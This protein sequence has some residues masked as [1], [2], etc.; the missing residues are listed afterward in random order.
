MRNARNTLFYLLKFIENWKKNVGPM[1]YLMFSLMILQYS[2][3]FNQQMSERRCWSV[4]LAR[5]RKNTITDT[6][7]H[8]THD[9]KSNIF[10][11]QVIVV[12]AQV[13]N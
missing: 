13:V 2:R 12:G 1:P 3:N 5:N 11:S 8:N 7:I 9:M 10:N 6:P 4:S